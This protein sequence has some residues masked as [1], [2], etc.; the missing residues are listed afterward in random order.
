MSDDNGGGSLRDE[1]GAA[2]HI[3]VNG[4]YAC[5]LIPPRP[6]FM[7]DM[8]AE[9]REILALHSAYWNR[10][11]E[12]GTAVLYGPVFGPRGAWGLGVFRAADGKAA[13][14]F[15]EAD[16]AVASGMA[17]CNLGRLAEGAVHE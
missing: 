2:A 4:L 13:R 5:E 17:T 1:G 16:P 6:T 7:E 9:E 8:T 14:A 10:A 3:K 15:V 12:R 11:I